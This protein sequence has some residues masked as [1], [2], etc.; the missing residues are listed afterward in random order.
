MTCYLRM[1]LK[2]L[3]KCKSLCIAA[4]TEFIQ[5]RKVNNQDAIENLNLW[6]VIEV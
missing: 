4:N 5:V 1:Q 2:Y 3:T 6:N